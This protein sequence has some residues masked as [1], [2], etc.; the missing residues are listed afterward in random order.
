MTFLVFIT[1]FIHLN[2]AV[3]Q[4]VALNDNEQLNKTKGSIH[5]SEFPIV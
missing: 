3:T 5:Y 4:Q 1:D 2:P